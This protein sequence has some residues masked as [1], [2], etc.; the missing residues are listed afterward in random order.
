LIFVIRPMAGWISLYGTDLPV[1]ERAIIAF[2]GI[3]GLGS[4][5]YLSYAAGHVEF[6]TAVS[7]LS[8]ALDVRS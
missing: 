6:V 7:K 1:A 2:Y 8:R 5:Y 4:I 3:R